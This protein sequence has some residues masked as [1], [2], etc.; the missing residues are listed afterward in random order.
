MAPLKM[1]INRRHRDCGCT[2]EI[3]LQSKPQADDV[4]IDDA[5][6]RKAMRLTG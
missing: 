2:V 4:E 5:P 6:M 3:A 1:T